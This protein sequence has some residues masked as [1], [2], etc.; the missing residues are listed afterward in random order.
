MNSEYR[1]WCKNKNEWEKHATLLSPDG[2]IVQLG[3]HGDLIKVNKENHI[4]QFYT[5]VKDKNGKK[6]FDGDILNNSEATEEKWLTKVEFSKGTF[7]LKE[8]QMNKYCTCF[9]DITTGESLLYTAD[10]WEIVG[11]IFENLELL[12]EK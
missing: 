7:H 5:G 4:V 11:N 3:H 2:E 9:C 1:V 8:I 10:N 6:I 12:E